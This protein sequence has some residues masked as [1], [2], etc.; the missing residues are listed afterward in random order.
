MGA[1]LAERVE[2]PDGILV[3]VARADVPADGRTA[4]IV[5]SVFPREEGPRALALAEASLF[6]LQGEI[7]TRLDRHPGPRIGF[8]LDTRAE[9][10]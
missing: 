9:N 1:L 4:T 5:L 8:A 7:Y 3:T 2:F 10:A 6:D